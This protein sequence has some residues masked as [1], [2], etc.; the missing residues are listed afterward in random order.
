M[1]L[2]WAASEFIGG[3][4]S[5]YSSV[6]LPTLNPYT[7]LT[8]SATGP[9][10]HLRYICQTVRPLLV[11]CALF[12]FAFGRCGCV[13]SRSRPIAIHHPGTRA[14]NQ[15]RST[16]HTHTHTHTH[17]THP[18]RACSQTSRAVFTVT[19]T[20]AH[21]RSKHARASSHSH[22]QACESNTRRGLS[23][24]DLLFLFSS[25]GFMCAPLHSRVYI[26]VC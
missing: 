23:V 9:L 8:V 13:A 22:F 21:P 18:K 7:G 3:M 1:G 4:T 17:I 12:W 16:N 10:G 26:F 19:H 14:P 6:K 25:R 2:R 5:F 11:R 20:H 24:R 15:S